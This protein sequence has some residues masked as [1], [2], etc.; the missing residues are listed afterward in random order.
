MRA[1]LE[2]GSNLWNG[3]EIYGPPERN[4][5]VL[6]NKYYAKYPEDASKVVLNIKGGMG[7][8]MLPDGSPEGVRRSVENSLKQLGSTGKID[9]FECA[10]KDPNTPIEVTMQA[11][12]ELVKEGK[13]GG[14]ALS[15]V[16]AN[17]IRQA[18]KVAKITA[19]EVEFSLFSTDVL[20]NGVA[21]AC[22]ELKI[23][24]LA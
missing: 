3:G 6:L 7:A 21:K 14:I 4:S 2:G 5:L 1:A 13:I 16:N 20:T 17:T 11:L 10:R 8:N 9:M 24:I 12:E 15:E 18:A 19:V 22:A 23:P